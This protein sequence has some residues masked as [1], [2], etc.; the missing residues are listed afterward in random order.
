M[1]NLKTIFRYKN[2]IIAFIIAGLVYFFVFYNLVNYPKI[3]F[4][5]GSHLH[6][7]KTL[8]NYGVYADFSSEGFRYYGP[9]IGVGPTV[10]LPIAASFAFFG[11]GLLQARLVM[12]VYLI[13]AILVFFLFVKY[14]SGSLAAIIAT[15]LLLTSRSVLF[16]YY[17]RQV[18]GEVPGFLFILSALLLWFRI[19][20]NSSWKNLGLVGML[21][22]LAAITKYQYLLFLIP[23]LGLAWLTNWVYYRQA[24]HR[25]FIIP[26]IFAGVL[27]AGWQ[28]YTIFYLGPATAAENWRLLQ[29]AAQGAAFNFN[30]SQISSNVNELTAR[31]VYLGAL[32]PSIIFAF[33]ISLPR[34]TNGQKWSIL[35]TLSILNLL[36]FVVSSIGWIRY[37][38]LGLALASLFIAKFFISIMDGYK[39]EWSKIFSMEFASSTI[40]TKFAYQTGMLL[41]LVAIISIPTVKNTFEIATASRTPSVVMATYLNENVP[42]NAIIETWDTEMG[43]LTNHRYH[44]PPNN[45]LALAVQQVYSGGEPVHIH[46][47]YV[48]TNKP[49]YIL[50]GEFSGWVNMYPV[51]LL[52]DT[53]QL[54]TEIDNF[55]LYKLIE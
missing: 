16:L 22:G 7:P 5:E 1:D 36:W 53:Y 49:E 21:F 54:I 13:L 6:V 52:S 30:L 11:I 27:F 14:L 2:I 28:A 31:S 12:A 43:F 35:F 25:T 29:T 38:F 51:E 19:W 33:F 37:A 24:P 42:Q 50:V 44:F 8:V 48:Q 4:D 39:L 45:L 26:A 15:V 23:M 3:W 34:T 41:W 47:N 20:G 17:G 32:L 10:M 18:L 40:N 9:T 55:Y 46:Y